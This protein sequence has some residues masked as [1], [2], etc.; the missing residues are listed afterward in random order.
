[1]APVWGS[2][3]DMDTGQGVVNGLALLEQVEPE[4]WSLTMAQGKEGLC[5][6]TVR[7]LE[8]L[9]VHVVLLLTGGPL[10][11]SP[12]VGALFVQCQ[13]DINEP[14]GIGSKGH[15]AVPRLQWQPHTLMVFV[16]LL[17]L[18]ERTPHCQLF[19]SLL[20]L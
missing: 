14:H 17:F 7:R 9:G 6:L 4:W 1:M 3:S 20:F 8:T 2:P 5:S 18:N 15:W 10:I 16:A 19:A 12:K 11:R 13:C